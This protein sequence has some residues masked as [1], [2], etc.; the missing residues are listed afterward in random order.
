MK[1]N[2]VWVMLPGCILVFLLANMIFPGFFLAAP[3]NAVWAGLIL[4]GLEIVLRPLLVAVC[5]PF[6]LFLFGATSLFIHIWMVYIAA[7]WAPGCEPGS[8][9][10]VLAVGAAVML[11]ERACVGLKEMMQQSKKTRDNYASSGI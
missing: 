6:N 4:W 7:V 9:W 10:Q 1:W 11:I 8:F 3:Q 2:W 5:L